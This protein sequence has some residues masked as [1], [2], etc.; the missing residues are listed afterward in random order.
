ME[1][2]YTSASEFRRGKGTRTIRTG[3]PMRFNR[4][5]G[6]NEA[7]TPNAIAIKKLSTLLK[8]TA[9]PTKKR[10]KYENDVREAE[11]LRFM[12]MGVLAQVFILM[13]RKGDILEDTDLE[14]NEI[15]PYIETLLPHREF[16]EET[17]RNRIISSEE[18]NI[19]RLRL[20]ATFV[21]YVRYVN[22]YVTHETEY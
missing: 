14:Y 7:N 9:I 5:R 11:Q 20:A 13:N 17:H 1:L 21:R 16:I 2:S 4:G 3:P 19:M 15:A 18:L 12:N 6:I 8:N 10:I 22:N